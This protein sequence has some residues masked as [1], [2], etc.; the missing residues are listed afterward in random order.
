MFDLFKMPEVSS[1]GA[2]SPEDQKK[3]MMV[4]MLQKQQVAPMSA[5][6]GALET[7]TNMFNK[8]LMGLM[9][10]QMMRQQ[11]PGMFTPGTAAN[12]GWS[13]EVK[14]AGLLSGLWG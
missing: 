1:N 5:A 3:R 6:P 8:G 4:Q 12:G 9:Q 2:L 10:G 11:E 7:G 14:P 13:T